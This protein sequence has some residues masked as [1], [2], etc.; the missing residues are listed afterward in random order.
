MREL[1]PSQLKLY[2]GVNV[3]P[4]DWLWYP[5]IPFG[6]VT[7]L[8]GD[9]GCGKSTLMMDI[10]A[11]V[12]NGTAN[13]Y[14]P[15][16]RK[17]MHVIYQC[18]ED[19]VAD[20]I[21]PRLVR[22]GANCDNVAFIDEE[23]DEI[24]INDEKVRRAIA[25]FNAKLLVIDPFQAYIGDYDM[26][27]AASIRKVLK[28]LGFW[29]AAY[30]CAIVLVGHLNKKQGNKDIYRGLGSIDLVAVARSVLKVENIQDS[31]TKMLKHIKSSLASKGE[32]LFFD[33]SPSHGIQ[34]VN[35][36]SPKEL[37]L[38]KNDINEEISKQEDTARILR[39]V[40]CD[41]PVSASEIRDMFVKNGVSEKTLRLTK[42]YMGIESFRKNGIWYWKIPSNGD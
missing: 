26:T 12:S 8:Q 20:T 15:D 9:P 42:K 41:G 29:A 36:H 18:S 23:I 34:W 5:Y 4:V 3:I 25:D 11:S 32:D 40:L 7:L 37:T 13:V 27:S 1:C 22:A 30:D 21:K 2:S 14:G 39:L 28:Q 6:K 19:S 17:P 24:T 35:I 33:I 10:I 31:E 38:P 16:L